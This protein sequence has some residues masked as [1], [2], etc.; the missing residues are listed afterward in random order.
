MIISSGILAQIN[1]NTHIAPVLLIF[2]YFSMLIRIKTF[3]LQDRGSNT[4][5]A[6]FHRAVAKINLFSMTFHNLIVI[7]GKSVD[8]DVLKLE[9]PHQH[10]CA[11]YAFT[12]NFR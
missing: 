9:T 12:R 11:Y 1:W 6:S 4:R 10:Y 7:K 5:L 2:Q 3:I 8:L